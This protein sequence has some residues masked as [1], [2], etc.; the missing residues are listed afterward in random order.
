MMRRLDRR[1][2]DRSVDEGH[3]LPPRLERRLAA[4][5]GL[6]R[7]ARALSSLDSALRQ[8]A[9]ELRGQA[10]PGIAQRVLGALSDPPRRRT[11]PVPYF[12]AVAAGLALAA[13]LW[14]ASSHPATRPAVAAQAWL[15]PARWSEI[16]SGLRPEE[17]LIDEARNLARD[18][19]SA[20]RT[21]WTRL[22]LASWL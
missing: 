19:Q 6:R 10:L 2:I 18:T 12:L 1:R 8:E 14:Q 20:A 16:A 7:F 21:L 13:W 15:D 4:D 3:P 22:P 9:I 11:S 17:A 5:A